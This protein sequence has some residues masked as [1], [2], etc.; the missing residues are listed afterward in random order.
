MST[1]GLNERESFWE[2]QPD[3]PKNGG[4]ISETLWGTDG[5]PTHQAARKRAQLPPEPSV[6]DRLPKF[7]H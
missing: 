3:E 4:R 1:L 5:G 6:A 2:T 7:T